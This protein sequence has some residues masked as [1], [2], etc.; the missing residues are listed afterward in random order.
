MGL[1]QGSGGLNPGFTLTAATIV[2]VYKRNNFH[3]EMG[4]AWSGFWMILAVIMYVDDMD[5]LLKTLRNHSIEEFFVF[6][7]AQIGFWG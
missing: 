1:G 7:Q 3:A 4:S 6:I 2:N 5:M